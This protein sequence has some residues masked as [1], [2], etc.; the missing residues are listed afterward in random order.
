MNPEKDRKPP[1]PRPSPIRWES[2]NRRHFVLE[3]GGWWNG[4]KISESH[5]GAIKPM[6]RQVVDLKALA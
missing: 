2:G 5:I 1:S 3:G 4:F 6:S